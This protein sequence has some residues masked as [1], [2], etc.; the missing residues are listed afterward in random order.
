[1]VSQLGLLDWAGGNGDWR[2]AL[3]TDRLWFRGS[4][5]PSLSAVCRSA[6]GG[7]TR[8]HHFNGAVDHYAA[9]TLASNRPG[10]AR[11]VDARQYSR[12]A[13]R[14]H[15]PPRRR[16]GGGP[17]VDRSHDPS[18]SRGHLLGPAPRTG[19]PTT[20]LAMRPGRDLAVGAI[21]GTATVL[22][23]MAGP[24][25]LIY[26]LLARAPAP[27]V[28]ATLLSFFGIVYGGVAVPCGRCR[29]RSQH[30]DWGGRLDPVR[31]ARRHCRPAARRPP[32]RPRL[33][34][35]RHRTSGRR[36][37]LHPC[38]VDRTCHPPIM[39]NHPSSDTATQTW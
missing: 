36:R 17:P 29:H 9:G 7:P 25:V 21:S 30:L 28:R 12:V 37:A 20:L 19:Q 31:R 23:G 22:V 5:D 35:A 39:A 18:L 16:S 26:L 1:M 6:S 33:R 38:S 34:H 14:A 15:C 3:H 11:A 2:I 27:T 24:P 32:R 8:Y 4:L 13:A 10:I